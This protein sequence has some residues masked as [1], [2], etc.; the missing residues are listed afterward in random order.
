MVKAF[1]KFKF[2]DTNACRQAFQRIEARG[3]MIIPFFSYLREKY[4]NICN[5]RKVRVR[6]V[7]EAPAYQV[8]GP[9][10][11]PKYC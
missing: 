6:G 1:S 2:L 10:H 4:I 9:A 11:N 7:V 5:E 8:Q 3:A